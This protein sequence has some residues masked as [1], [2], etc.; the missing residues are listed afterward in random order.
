DFIPALHNMVAMVLFMVLVAVAAVI[1]VARMSHIKRKGQ[2]LRRQEVM[3]WLKEL[4]VTP[5]PE[6]D[7][8]AGKERLD[9]ARSM[10]QVREAADP[11]RL[12]ETVDAYDTTVL[13]TAVALQVQE[14]IVARAGVGADAAMTRSV[15]LREQLQ[16]LDEERERLDAI[17]KSYWEVQDQ[18][19]Q[20]MREI[21]PL[22]VAIRQSAR[23]NEERVQMMDNSLE[24]FRKSSIIKIGEASAVSRGAYVVAAK[25]VRV[26]GSERPLGVRVGVPPKPEVLVPEVDERGEDTPLSITPPI[27]RLRTRQ[28]MLLRE[29][30]AEL[31][32]TV[33]NTLAEDVEELAVEF[34]I[35]G[36]RLRH[37]GPHKVELGT[38]VTGRSAGATF[39]MRVMPPPP[40]DEE[41]E[42]LT[43]VLARVTGVAGSRKV[44]QELPSKTTTL[45]SSSLERP[46]SFGAGALFQENVKLGRRGVRFPRVPSN[47]VLSALE[48]PHGMLPVMDGTMQGGGTW[49]ILGS[50][51]DA[52]EPLVALIGVD[53]GPEW[54]DLFVEVR[55]PPR[56]PSR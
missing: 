28:A 22:M 14:E 47:V 35:V 50:R 21:W 39:Q 26:K 44:R 1:P 32:V 2:R 16:E 18:V 40:A 45:V 34:T 24:Q 31:V 30:T 46:S 53:T 10:Y 15:R 54:V 49:R 11:P 42:E 9:M 38:L 36:D 55:G 4:G 51:T 17:C 27:G 29:D 13:N 48:F 20:E 52:D 33:D 41:P 19:D 37:K 6:M 8:K 7:T 56:F 3:A 43:R 23:A 12:R 25:E 5:E